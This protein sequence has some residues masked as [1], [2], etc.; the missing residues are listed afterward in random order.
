MIGKNYYINLG[1]NY[2]KNDKIGKMLQIIKIANN[3]QNSHNKT[4]NIKDNIK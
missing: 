2:Y 4:L 3:H 1:Q